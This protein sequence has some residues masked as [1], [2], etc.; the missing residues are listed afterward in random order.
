VRFDTGS[1]LISTLAIGTR[2]GY[3]RFLKGMYAIGYAEGV[4]ADLEDLRA[5][6]RSRILDE[7]DIQLQHQPTQETRHKKVLVGLVPPWEHVEPLWQLRVGEYRVF[8]DVNDA[9]LVVIVRAIRHKP[10]H[11]A[12]EDIL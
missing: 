8:Y 6:D 9:E 10:P 3:R 5:Y 2:E 4:A 1:L 7:I 11:K 12:T